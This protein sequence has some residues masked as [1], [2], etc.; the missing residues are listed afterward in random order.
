MQPRIKDFL[1]HLSR[2]RPA[3]SLAYPPV[4][5]SLDPAAFEDDLYILR[6]LE[7]ED[8]LRL[9]DLDRGSGRV[10]VELTD[11]GRAWASRLGPQLQR[12]QPPSLRQ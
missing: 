5:G 12:Q 2:H 4:A 1:S 7:A 8:F 9:S 3:A 10:R 6:E 11:A